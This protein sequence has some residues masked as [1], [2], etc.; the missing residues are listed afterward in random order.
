MNKHR[1][2][3]TLND[4]ASDFVAEETFFYVD[5]GKHFLYLLESKRFIIFRGE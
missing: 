4:P 3:P 5:R 2:E 1:L